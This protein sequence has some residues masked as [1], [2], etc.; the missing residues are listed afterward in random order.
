MHCEYSDYHKPDCKFELHCK[1]RLTV[2]ICFY[3]GLISRLQIC[4]HD[5]VNL[6]E[7]RLC[8]WHTGVDLIQPSKVY[9]SN[10]PACRCWSLLSQYNSFNYRSNSSITELHFY[11]YCVEPITLTSIT[12]KTITN[13]S[14]K[15][16]FAQN[17]DISFA[18]S[19]ATT[20]GIASYCGART[21]ILFPIHSFLNISGTTLSLQTSNVADVG[22]YNVEL[23]VSLANYP[24]VPSITKNFVVTITCEVQTLTFTT[25]P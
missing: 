21:Y 23:K 5:C 8:F 15:V 10:Q 25:S 6:F 11:D 2:N 4:V 13:M 17:Q 22:V 7:R 19:V 16:S 20:N 9:N 18:D 14:I 24:M 1:S 12:D 3:A